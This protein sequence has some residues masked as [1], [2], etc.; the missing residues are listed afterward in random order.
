VNLVTFGLGGTK[1]TFLRLGFGASAP[2]VETRVDGGVLRGQFRPALV[3]WPILLDVVSR[4]RVSLRIRITS[5]SAFEASNRGYVQR[6]DATG[7]SNVQRIAPPRAWGD[8]GYIRGGRGERAFH[9]L[10][11]TAT[12]L[13]SIAAMVDVW[14]KRFEGDRTMTEH[15]RQLLRDTVAYLRATMASYRNMADALAEPRQL[16]V[17]PKAYEVL[18]RYAR[19]Q[20]DARAQQ[21]A[22]DVRAVLDV[23]DVLPVFDALDRDDRMRNVA[24]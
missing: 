22:R 17:R 20:R 18:E 15:D 23:L 24:G 7:S 8:G 21:D 14:C 10:Q 16:F 6:C 9:Q 12:D 5:K 13:N 1:A 2:A 4:S 19:E 3:N 11:R